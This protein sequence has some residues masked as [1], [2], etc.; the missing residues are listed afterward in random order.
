MRLLVSIALLLSPIA[1]AGAWIGPDGKPLPET[2][3]MRSV[4]DFGVQVVLTP[5]EKEFRT[6]WN[7]GP[8]PPT[9]KVAAKVARGGSLSAM[10]IFHGCT[11]NQS[12][13]CNSVIEFALVSP[14]GKRLPAGSGPL[15][16]DAPLPGKL[17][18]AAASATIGFDMT[19][20][21]GT[22][23]V[24]AIAVDKVSG[25]RVQVQASFAVL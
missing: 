22:Y 1:V 8:T 19:D 24:M 16:M 17:M 6:A 3:S 18:L 11:P 14:D 7:A 2:E 13:K 10:I 23:R 15:W 4:G 21:T 12:G 5:D 20:P 9:L 25:K